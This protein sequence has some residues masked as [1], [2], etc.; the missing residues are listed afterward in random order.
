MTEWFERRAGSHVAVQKLSQMGEQVDEPVM[1][2]Y[3]NPVPDWVNMPP[4]LD[5]TEPTLKVMGATS[6]PCPKCNGASGTVRHLE[7]SEGYYVAECERACGFVWYELPG[8]MK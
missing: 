4:D 8:G 5:P 3:G 2:L 7:L 6:G 1:M